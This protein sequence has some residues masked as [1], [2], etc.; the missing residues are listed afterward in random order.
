MLEHIAFILTG[1][2]VPVCLLSVGIFYSVR[3]KLFH[4]LKPRAVLRSLKSEN[5]TSGVRAVTLAL[6]GTL[7]V[8]NIVGVS[9]AI[10]L[11]GFGAVFWMWASALVAMILKYAEIVLAM[12]HK[13]SGE[14][15]A[16]SYIYDFLSSLGFRRLAAVVSS[17]FAAVF[18]LNSLTM[19]SML[20][21]NAVAEALEGVVGVPVV[22]TGIVLAATSFLVIRRGT[23][24]ITA[25]TD[26]L[27]PIMSLG[28]AVLSLAVIIKDASELPEALRLIFSSA[29][30]PRAAVGGVGGFSVMHSV[31][32]G[33]MRGLVSNEAGC[34]TAPTA[35]ALAQNTPAR[36]G[37]WGIFEVFA[38]TVIL[39]T[40][41]ALVVILEYDTASRHGGSYM[42][43]TLCAFESALGRFAPY[44]LSV[45]VVCFGLATVLCWAHYGLS[46][47]RFFS[48][49][50]RAKT[51]FSLVYCACVFTGA[52]MSSEHAWL[53]S[54]LAMG[55]MTVIN[56]AVIVGMSGEVKKETEEYL[57][58]IK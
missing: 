39:C 3:L 53:L 46:C 56:L 7:G 43:M 35:H 29:F 47:V 50:K 17:V 25:L 22:A 26:I 10:H 33:V 12:R 27:V 9:S 44:L 2:A 4:I 52:F 28:Y 45:A 11:G 19:G 30:S 1:I 24:G 58:G 38:D 21:S 13:K 49:R 55:I 6:A 15:G 8:G 51:A 16:M 18:L 41:T 5:G 42:T 54:D 32:Y 31:R 23:K 36:Q 48:G 20:Q 14:G 40:M 57:Q 37:M 34:G